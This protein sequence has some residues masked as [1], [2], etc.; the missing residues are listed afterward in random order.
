MTRRSQNC[1]R[2][3]TLVELLVVIAIIGI[4]IGLL[5]P[6]VQAAREAARRM[7][8]TNNFK[9]LGLALM[10]YADV[11]ADTFPAGSC[12]F[13]GFDQNKGGVGCPLN[14]GIVFLLPYFERNDIYDT[15]TRFARES[16][17]DRSLTR[18][19]GAPWDLAQ[20]NRDYWY[21]QKISVLCCPS[22]GNAGLFESATG[23]SATNVY[24]CAGD[25]MW[26]FARRPDQEWT[27]RSSIGQR[28][29]WQREVWKKMSAITDGT[30]NTISLSECVVPVTR[31]TNVVRQGAVASYQPHD[32]EA[33][34]QLCLNNAYA[35]DRLTVKNPCTSLWRGRIWSNGRAADAWF[36]CTLPPNSV[37]CVAGSFNSNE[38]GSF[39]PTSYHAG[40]VNILRVDG[41]V[42]FA[43]DTIDTGDLSAAQVTSGQSPYGVWGAL[44]SIN[45][46]EPKSSL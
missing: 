22:D 27:T 3:F 7:Q 11:N 17:T 38:W 1:R 45:G 21:G 9:Q 39:A 5:L 35:A 15:Y 44:G 34:P 29:F 40:G 23:S 20:A 26:T 8:C 41:S 12:Y 16:L 28:A 6:A 10:N 2:G 33:R 4:L 25:G 24:Y 14:G 42:A 18:G 32:G 13:L 30:S 43:S 31:S 46:G 37:S 36:T 19:Y